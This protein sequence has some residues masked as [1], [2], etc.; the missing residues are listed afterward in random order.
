M[1]LRHALLS[2]VLVAACDRPLNLTCIEDV[3]CL[4]DGVPGT[5]INSWCALPAVECPSGLR[6]WDSD[7]ADDFRDQGQCVPAD[8]GVRPR[9]GGTAR[10]D[11]PADAVGS[12]DAAADG[13]ARDGA[14]LDGP[15]GADAGRRDGPAPDGPRRDGP[16]ADGPRP[17]GPR[18]DGPRADGSAPDARAA[19]GPLL[20]LGMGCMRPEQCASNHCRDGVCCDQSCDGLCVRCDTSAARGRCTGLAGLDPDAECTGTG[21][22]GG[23]CGGAG[24]CSF[25]M[26][27]TSCGSPACAQ[28]MLSEPRCDG[29]GTCAAVSRTCFPYA[30][31]AAGT[32]CA[33]SCSGATG[34]AS[35][36]FCDGSVCR[37]SL[38]P[39][40]DCT[41]GTAC[42]SG[43]CVDGVCC[44][45]DCTG[46]CSACNLPGTR[47]MCSAEPAG[48]SCGTPTCTSGQLSTPTC[49][50]GGACQAASTSCGAYQCTAAGTSCRTSCGLDSDCAS[51]HFCRGGSCIPKLGNGT[52]CNTANECTSGVCVDGVCCDR[53]CDGWCEACN[54]SGSIGAC[55]PIGQLAQV[56][57]DLRVSSTSPI[58][59]LPQIAWTG[60][61]FAVAW[62]DLSAGNITPYLGRVTPQGTAAGAQVQVAQ[63]SYFGQSLAAGLTWNGNVHAVVWL[64]QDARS[65]MQVHL[66]RTTS[67]GAFV[68]SDADVTAASEGIGEGGQ[69]RRL[70]WNAV[71]R[72]WMLVYGEPYLVGGSTY[73]YR[74]RIARFSEALAPLSDQ[75]LTMADTCGEAIA[76]AD[77]GYVVLTAAAGTARWNRL[78]GAGIREGGDAPI[79]AGPSAAIGWS[80]SEYALA[81]RCASGTG[82]TNLCFRRYSEAG[83]ALGSLLTYPAAVRS[84]DIWSPSLIWAGDRWVTTWSEGTPYRVVVAQVSAAGTAFGTNYTFMPA[85]TAW[86]ENPAIAWGGDRIG[87]SWG[88][89]RDGGNLEVYFAVLA[90]GQ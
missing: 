9:D 18:V 62:T 25:P 32:G 75:V 87:V 5:C 14:A 86:M 69:R 61:E 35:G 1:L 24:T 43:R 63:P 80:G 76:R 71:R 72:E 27:S 34:C 40:S 44:E 2:L 39:G 36:A 90:C 55:T 21:T 58:S 41:T 19:D 17:D 59:E 48:T 85:T 15:S 3:E 66:Q 67:S 12:G 84:Y 38:P 88:D 57:T 33:S 16:A 31:A 82:A 68:G 28:G 4:I 46:A 13:A 37:A 83:E 89:R 81:W 64:R 22:C 7:G 30:C 49:A 6:Y 45:S 79:D 56:G 52:G 60:S 11:G 10:R 8:G 47:G 77:G 70:V 78:D 20:D 29:A 51:G 42:A 26:M 54:R 73:G 50:A 53:A 23:V 74:C 65:R